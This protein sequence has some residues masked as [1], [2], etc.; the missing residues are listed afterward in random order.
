MDK[1]FMEAVS[2]LGQ[3]E[4]EGPEDNPTIVNFAKE[5]GFEWV[6]DDETPWCSIFMNWCA[7]KADLER[8][9]KVNARSWLLVGDKTENPEPGDVVVL[10]RGSVDSWQGHV[11]ILF[12]FSKDTK[13]VYILGGN[14]GNQV[15]IAG[16]PIDQ[17]LGYRRLRPV[18]P[19]DIPDITLKMGAKGDDV[20]VLQ[21]AL[22]VAGFDC[23]TT[24]GDFGIKT[25]RA[26]REL[27]STK[28]N[29]KIDGV[30]GPKT[31]AYLI[32]ILKKR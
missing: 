6:D 8:S 12:G 27:Q 16:F 23:G 20:K 15:S 18:N 25:E 10:W 1:L 14:Q 30:F 17:V 31:R 2:Q 29:L 24:D 32:E 28:T 4:I 5:S 3:K 7:L 22:K 11:G 21:D 13:R 9:G 26:V 19:I